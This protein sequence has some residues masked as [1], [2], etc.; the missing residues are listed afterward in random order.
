MKK[1]ALKFILLA[2][3]ACLASIAI[4]YYVV[5]EDERIPFSIELKTN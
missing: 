2:A 4:Y 1:T 5:P 3:I